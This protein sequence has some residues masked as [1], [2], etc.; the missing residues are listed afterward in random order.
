[1]NRAWT[2]ENSSR[3]ANLARTPE[4]GWRSVTYDGSVGAA[5]SADAVTVP[6]PDSTTARETSIA[7][8]LERVDER[9][10]ASNV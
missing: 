9:R 5:G 7:T 2:R 8:M 3:A 4:P 10:E 1:M 6:V